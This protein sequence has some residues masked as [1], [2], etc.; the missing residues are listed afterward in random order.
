MTALP[1]TAIL[2]EGRA[3]PRARGSVGAH[4]PRYS[5][6]GP[7]SSQDGQEGGRVSQALG[8]RALGDA[9]HR[10]ARCV[11]GQHLEGGRACVFPG[12]PEARS[13]ESTWPVGWSRVFT[14]KW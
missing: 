4:P 2:S 14:G 11:S 3:P 1:P 8:E 6:A 7:D 12:N 10:G 13:T 9:G 5:A